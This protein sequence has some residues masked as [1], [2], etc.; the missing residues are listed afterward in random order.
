MNT[1][2]L[3]YLRIQGHRRAGPFAQISVVDSVGNETPR[4]Y[5]RLD[6]GADLTTVPIGTIKSAGLMLLPSKHVAVRDV[7]GR[8]K[9]TWTYIAT[10]R[11][12]NDDKLFYEKRMLYGLLRTANPTPLIAMDVISDFD[13]TSRGNL[14]MLK[15]RPL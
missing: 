15:R 13:I 11:I 3:Y 1:L 4:M 8:C 5:A 9:S 10:L 14:W 7:H 2:S 6:T 12:W